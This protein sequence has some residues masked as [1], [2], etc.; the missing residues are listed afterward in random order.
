MHQWTFLVKSADATV[1][2]FSVAAENE[3]KFAA[4]KTFLAS[5]ETHQIFIVDKQKDFIGELF[6]LTDGKV[7]HEFI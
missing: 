6:S 3:R 7:S 1:E 4:K 2:K 5:Y